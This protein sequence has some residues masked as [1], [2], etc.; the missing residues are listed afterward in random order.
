ML[1]QRIKERSSAFENVSYLENQTRGRLTYRRYREVE[2]FE[3]TFNIKWI[4]LEG[5]QRMV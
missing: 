4:G 5:M 3:L 1:G 2:I